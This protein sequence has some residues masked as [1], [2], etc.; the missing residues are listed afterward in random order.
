MFRRY[1]GPKVSERL[2]ERFSTQNKRARF[3][4]ETMKIQSLFVFCVCVVSCAAAAEPVVRDYRFQGSISKA[5]LENYLSRATTYC[6]LLSPQGTRERPGCSVEEGIRF[7]T[8]TGAKFVGRSL[9]MWGGESRLPELLKAGKAAAEKVHQADP[10]IVLQ[11]CAFEIATA[12]VNTLAVP[13]WVFAEFGLTAEQR[14]FDLDAMRYPP[15]Q[16]RDTW[17][18]DSSII[19]DISRVETQMWFFYMIASYIDI[20]VE[21]IHLGQV[22]IMNE[23]DPDNNCWYDL[24]SRTRKYARKHAR[25][26]FVIFDAHVPGGGIMKDGKLLLDFHSFPLRI[27]EL[28]AP[29]Q[30]GH[31]KVGHYDSIYRRSAGGVTPSGWSCEALSYLVEFD[32]FGRSG[33]EGEKFGLHWIW[34]YDEIGW[35][36]R[37]PKEY[38]EM[39]LYYAWHWLKVNDP[40]GHLQM[41]GARVLHSPVEGKRWYWANNSCET[42]PTGFGD[43]DVIKA[44]WAA[45]Q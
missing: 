42:F 11:A 40:S 14:N 25:R 10:D 16:Y 5:V 2:S 6:E 44:I 29:G 12:D 18:R 24:V 41:P 38:R 22:E 8:N 35:F 36:A 7:L 13:E 3:C 33:H 27:E 4:I 37:Q 26:G 20:G 32:N 28:D 45:D 17:G 43:E 21:A 9:Y 34:G 15:N 39:W 1:I 19:P 30:Q 31:L 23:R